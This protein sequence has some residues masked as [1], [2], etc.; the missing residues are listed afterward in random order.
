MFVRSSSHAHRHNMLWGFSALMVWVTVD[1]IPFSGRLLSPRWCTRVVLGQDWSTSAISNE[2]THSCGAT[3]NVDFVN[4]TSHPFKNSMIQRT[5]SSLI[6]LNIISITFSTLTSSTLGC[7]TIYNLRRR[8]HTQLLPQHRGHLMDSNFITK[9]LYKNIYNWRCYE[10]IYTYTESMTNWYYTAS[11]YHCCNHLAFCQAWSLNEYVMLC[12]IM[13]CYVEIVEDDRYLE[14]R[15]GVERM[16][17]SRDDAGRRNASPSEAVGNWNSHLRDLQSQIF[18][19]RLSSILDDSESTRTDR[20]SQVAL[21]LQRVG[22]FPLA[23]RF[24]VFVVL[25][26]TRVH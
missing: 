12:Y 18:H 19:R 14:A 20:I 17:S 21:E 24:K 11:F 9:I 23:W 5:S 4:Q 2:S 22:L 10:T 1:F 25:L 3:R 6:K 7:L 15:C 8:P 13:L 16:G 26:R